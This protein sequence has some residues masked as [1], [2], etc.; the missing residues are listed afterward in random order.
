MPGMKPAMPTRTNTTPASLA[1]VCAAER[2][3]HPARGAAV[4]SVDMSPPRWDCMLPRSG[5]LTQKAQLGA[6][7][8]PANGDRFTD[9]HGP[10]QRLDRARGRDRLRRDL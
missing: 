6:L 2:V 4:G 10:D 7:A 5:K 8:V 1:T 9:E 3:C